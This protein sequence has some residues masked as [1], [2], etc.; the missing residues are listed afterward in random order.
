MPS[1]YGE[2]C[3]LC[4]MLAA[5]APHF[6]YKLFLSATPHNG[7]TRSSTGLLEL[8]DLVRFSRTNELSQL[9]RRRI[10][11]VFVRRLKRDI[12]AATRTAKPRFCTCRPPVALELKAHPTEAELWQAFDTFRTA[13]H[14]LISSGTRQRRRADAFA[15]EVLGKRL[16]SCPTAFAES[17]CRARQGFAKAQA[18]SESEMAAAERSLRQRAAQA[19]KPSNARP[20]PRPSPTHG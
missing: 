7:H 9:A 17:W 12:K 2:D 5:V 3:K 13:M 4:R 11:E 16:L 20:P 10:G 8:L 1:P 19:A 14:W 18:A 6:E 15:V